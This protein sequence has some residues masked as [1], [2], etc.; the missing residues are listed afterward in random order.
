MEV[1]DDKTNN[2]NVS[3]NDVDH[4]DDISTTRLV[5]EILHIRGILRID[6]SRVE[7]IVGYRNI[8]PFSDFL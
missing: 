6:D 4:C 2:S 7:H 3:Y 1:V 8:F 5:A